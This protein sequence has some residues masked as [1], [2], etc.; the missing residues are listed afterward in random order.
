[1]IKN[2]LCLFVFNN[3]LINS[4]DEENEND[5]IEKE[6]D[7]NI[8]S[9]ELSSSD[10]FKINE[11]PNINLKYFRK[12][13]ETKEEKNFITK[14]IKTKKK[15]ELCK[16]WEVYHD[17]Y[18]KKECSFAHGIEELRTGAFLKKSKNKICKNFEEKGYCIFGNRCN[19]RHLIKEKRYF[20]YES[21]LNYTFNEMYKEIQKNMNKK[22][23]LI[24][25]YKKIL[26]KRKIMVYVII[27]N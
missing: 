11:G 15:T 26:L 8:K 23:T 2:I 5:S 4:S 16:N 21:L 17:C 27:Y 19:Y 1:M 24:K 18:F 22:Y 6:E 10:K 7:K 9:I 25:I 14:K 13:Y 20:T 3:E 12:T